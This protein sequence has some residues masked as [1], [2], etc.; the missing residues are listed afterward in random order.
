MV[1]HWSCTIKREIIST[2]KQ[3]DDVWN[4]FNI[5]CTESP[6]N[7]QYLQ[8]SNTST[9]MVDKIPDGQWPQITIWSGWSKTQT[10][11]IHLTYYM[12][13]IIHQLFLKLHNTWCIITLF[14]FCIK[15]S[16]SSAV[17]TWY[18]CELPPSWI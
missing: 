7:L 11:V 1:M 8:W 6:W 4:Q 18:T 9:V 10:N 3:Y 14:L 16:Q 15:N 17:S 2:S 12:F 5:Q 13:K